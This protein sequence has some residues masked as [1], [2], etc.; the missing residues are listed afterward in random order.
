MRTSRFILMLGVEYQEFQFLDQHLRML[1]SREG[2]LHHQED[3][4]VV[5]Q[6]LWRRV[7][8]FTSL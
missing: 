5:A 1:R 3:Q 6:P 4:A 8:L 7:S 2:L